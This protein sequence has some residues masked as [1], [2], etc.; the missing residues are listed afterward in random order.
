MTINKQ[1]LKNFLKLLFWMG[2]F[3]AGTFFAWK[4]NKEMNAINDM[5]KIIT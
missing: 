3:A 4:V 1:N 5:L 2:V